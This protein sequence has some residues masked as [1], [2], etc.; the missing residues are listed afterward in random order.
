MDRPSP[1]DSD[2][3]DLSVALRRLG[4][5]GP[6]REAAIDA[7]YDRLKAM[8]HRILSG[9]QPGDVLQPTML[10]HDL[11][12][13][14]A[15]QQKLDIEDREHFFALAARVMQQIVIDSHRHARRQ[16]RG[17]EAQVGG[18]TGATLAVPRSTHDLEALAEAITEL[19]SRDAR[20]ATVV[21]L[22]FLSG[23]T[24]E[25]VAEMLG[26]SVPTVERDWRFARADLRTRLVS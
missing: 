6:H 10:V 23:M 26:I 20:A 22:K 11:Y 8:A 14:V 12:A 13:R 5:P 19:E 3:H 25:E 16:R 9:R 4:E 1:S 18:L 21:R 7:I 24:T 2:A 17:G 15:A